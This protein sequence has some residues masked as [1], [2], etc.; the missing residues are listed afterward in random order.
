MLINH[1]LVRSSS[2]YIRWYRSGI[3]LAIKSVIPFVMLA[4]L[5]LMVIKN[6]RK[7]SIAFRK[8]SYA[9][10]SENRRN[11]LQQ[12]LRIFSITSLIITMFLLTHSLLIFND[13]LEI[14]DYERFVQPPF[15]NIVYVGNLLVAVNSAVHFLIYCAVGRRFRNE[16]LRQLCC[17]K[18]EVATSENL[19]KS[20]ITGMKRTLPSN[21]SAKSIIIGTK[22]HV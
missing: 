15:Q 16:F 1:F 2:F 18:E 21:C 8:L 12:K 20:G 22:S 9:F 3:L 17:E 4:V 7:T 5:N 10:T 6:L 19:L 11:R 13:F 14:F